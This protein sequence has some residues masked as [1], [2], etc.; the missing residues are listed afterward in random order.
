MAKRGVEQK[1][2]GV[3]LPNVKTEL[4][5]PPRRVRPEG[6]AGLYVRSQRMSEGVGF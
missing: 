3:N 4:L 1:R 6:L 5:P 2:D